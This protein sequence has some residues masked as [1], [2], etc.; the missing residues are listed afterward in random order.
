MSRHFYKTTFENEPIT[1]LMGYDNYYDGF[2][3]VIE[4][5]EPKDEDVIYSNLFENDCYPKNL[6]TH[7]RQLNALNLSVPIEMIIEIHTD[8]AVRM[9]NKDVHHSYINGIHTRH[10]DL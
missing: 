7:Q 9:G 10:Q 3:M 6:S 1:I 5:D 8:A 2:F 4:Y